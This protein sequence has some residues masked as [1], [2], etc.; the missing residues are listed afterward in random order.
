VRGATVYHGRID[1][2]YRFNREYLT[3]SWPY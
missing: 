2:G 3:L 1:G